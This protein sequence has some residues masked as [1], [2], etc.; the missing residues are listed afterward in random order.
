MTDFIEAVFKRLP[1]IP[2]ARDVKSVKDSIV[3]CQ[4]DGFS[5][6]DTVAY[7][8]ATEEVSPHLEEEDALA[9]MRAIIHKYPE[10]MKFKPVS[11]QCLIGN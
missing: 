9:I 2:D 7:V 3:R 5:F 1:P 6:D 4:E 8:K 10:S 11:A